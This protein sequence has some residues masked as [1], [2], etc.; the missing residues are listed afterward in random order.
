MLLIEHTTITIN[1]IKCHHTI[2]MLL[3]E[4]TTNTINYIRVHHIM[5]KNDKNTASL[6]SVARGLYPPVYGG[7]ALR[8]R[9]YRLNCNTPLVYSQQLT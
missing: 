8:A 9:T 3:I 5:P 2:V 4:H 7:L 6:R 1:R